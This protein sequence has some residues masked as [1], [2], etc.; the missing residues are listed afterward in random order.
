MDGE[1]RGWMMLA[2]A[3]GLIGVAAGAFAAHG[4]AAPMAKEWMRTGSTYQLIHAVACL[5][6]VAL[7][8]RTRVP[9]ALFLGGAILFSGSLYAMALGAPLWLGAVT[10]VGG[11]LFMAGWATL[12]LAA[13]RAPGR[14]NGE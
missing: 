10:P 1:R 9:T 7:P 3:S 8:V 5:A 2:A 13:A 6:C 14:M 12:I 11:L 4:L